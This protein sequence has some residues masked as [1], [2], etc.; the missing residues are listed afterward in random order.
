MAELTPPEGPVSRASM[1]VILSRFRRLS[2]VK[3]Y[4]PLWL[5]G[6]IQKRMDVI[7]FYYKRCRLSPGERAEMERLHALA[8]ATEVKLQSKVGSMLPPHL[9]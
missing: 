9:Q 3:L 7:R 5:P 2:A 6:E 8:A 4:V 1:H